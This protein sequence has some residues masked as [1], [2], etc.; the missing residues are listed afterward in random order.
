MYRFENVYA[1]EGEDFLGYDLLLRDGSHF[2]Q[3]RV[4]KGAWE[5]KEGLPP[6]SKWSKECPLADFLSGQSYALRCVISRGKVPFNWEGVPWPE[7][8]SAPQ[9]ADLC[10]RLE[11]AVVEALK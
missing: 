6:L 3:T 9:L 7:P 4:S 8:L 10:Q 11:V 2:L 5:E 1:R